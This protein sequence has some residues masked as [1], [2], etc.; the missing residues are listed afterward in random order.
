MKRHS[1][2]WETFYARRKDTSGGNN[3]IAQRDIHYRKWRITRGIQEH[4]ETDINPS[5]PT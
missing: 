4:L 5:G 3:S 1:I 2:Y